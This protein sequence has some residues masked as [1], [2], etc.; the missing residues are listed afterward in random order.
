[1]EYTTDSSLSF[2]FKGKNL[3]RW[4]KDHLEKG[5]NQKFEKT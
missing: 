5:Q 2:Y 3:R 1:M 4:R